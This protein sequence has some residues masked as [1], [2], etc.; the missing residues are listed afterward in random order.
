MEQFTIERSE[1]ESCS[2]RWADASRVLGG[3][4]I[5]GAQLQ[6]GGSQF[7]INYPTLQ[8]AKRR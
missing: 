3:L 5:L 6:P 1:A 4:Q 7:D 2:R 8:P